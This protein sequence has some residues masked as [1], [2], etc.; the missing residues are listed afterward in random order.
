MACFTSG[1]IMKSAS[2]CSEPRINAYS[3]KRVFFLTG[4][5]LF[6]GLHIAHWK[7]SGKTLA[8]LELNE[9][10]YTLHLGI[11]TAG[12]IFM[13]LLLIFSLI[14]GRFF[15][16]WLCHILALQDFSVWILS[17]F[18]IKPRHIKSRTF[19]LIPVITMGYLF[20]LP[21]IERIYHSKPMPVWKIQG[22]AEG[23]ASFITN[24][25]WRN[26]PGA[27]ITLLTFFICGF[28]IIYFLGSRSFCQYVCP[29][30]ALFAVS[31]RLAP[32]KIKLTGNCN[33]CGICSSVCSS[34][35]LVHREVQEFGK[36]VNHNC[37]KDLDC[38]AS[39]P[40]NALSFGFTK[41]SGLKSLYLGNKQKIKFDFTLKEDIALLVLFIVFLSIYFGLYDSVAFL[42]A[43]A[44]A[45]IASAACL[46][47]YNVFKSEH[48]KINSLILKQNRKLRA[49]GKVFYGLFAV[50]ILFSTHSAFIRYHQLLGEHYYNRT[51]N[52]SNDSAVELQNPETQ[53][54]INN[55]ARL[56]GRVYT[57]G[58]YHSPA[59]LRQLASLSIC[60]K[61]HASATR[62][63]EEMLSKKT[64]ETD[65]R[66]RLAKL[67][68]VQNNTTQALPHL[69]ELSKIKTE[70]LQDKMIISDA[71]LTLGHIEERNGFTSEALHLYQKAIEE[72]PKNGEAYL[73]A[74]VL[75]TRSQKYDQAEQYLQKASEL[76]A[77]VVLIENTLAF[78][79]IRKHKIEEAALHLENVI[80]ADPGNTQALKNLASLR[81][82][83]NKSNP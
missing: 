71:M 22:D 57:Y 45:V 58:L 48:F 38:V 10:L 74:G 28:L 20:L 34:H 60:R 67:Y 44:S 12:F 42:L 83:N 68:I 70:I 29:Y 64:D 27:G 78:I 15:C 52:I 6:M 77:P 54:D 4:V 5:Y 73:A 75:A 16:S 23:W 59:L 21:Q 53:S 82:K 37:L 3:R 56:L 81:Q 1:I 36:V 62:Y 7:F 41:P 49:S 19:Y 33:N 18:H 65:A 13:A 43:A 35:I 66:L 69:R 8:P 51:A 9:V 80:R 50:L 11:I 30:G 40:E 26:L 61:D 55:A 63:L 47:F 17:K 24:D 76:N 72:N 79:Y 31:D 14:A 32:G 46:T 39:C 25:F 2:G